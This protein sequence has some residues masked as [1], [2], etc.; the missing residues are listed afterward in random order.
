MIPRLFHQHGCCSSNEYDPWM[1]SGYGFGRRW[2]CRIYSYWPI[3]N[4]E[5]DHRK[6]PHPNQL[7]TWRWCELGVSKRQAEVFTMVSCLVW[8]PKNLFVENFISREERLRTTGLHYSLK[9]RR[10]T[11]DTFNLIATLCIS[12]FCKCT[13]YLALAEVTLCSI[14]YILKYIINRTCMILQNEKWK[15]E[16]WGFIWC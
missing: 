5:T 12:L 2:L 10:E 9:P 16:S 6:R 3:T 7:V 4:E 11:L 1:L 13:F 14:R 15:Q 8:T